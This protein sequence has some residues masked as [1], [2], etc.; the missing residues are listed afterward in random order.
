MG[1]AVLALNR[2]VFW[3]PPDSGTG[4]EG[5]LMTWLPYLCRLN[6]SLPPP[7]HSMLHALV[8][9]WT[10]MVHLGGEDRMIVISR[11]AT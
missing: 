6:S 3:C 10:A 7:P 9:L 1:P 5:H 11:W 4:L 8:T 2:S